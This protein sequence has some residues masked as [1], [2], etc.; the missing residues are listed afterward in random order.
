MP[1]AT[2]NL[3]AAIKAAF[4][5]QAAKTDGDPHDSVVEIAAD[6]ASAI[7]AFVLSATVTTTFTGTA[8]AGP[9]PVTGAATGTVS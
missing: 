2:P 8:V 9:Y 7:E 3:E 4:E 1:L 5:K 6:L